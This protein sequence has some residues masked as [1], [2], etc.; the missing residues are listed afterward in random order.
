MIAPRVR[1]NVLR[2]AAASG[3]LALCLAAPQLAHAACGDGTLDVNEQC[4]DGNTASG[5]CCSATCSLEALGALCTDDGDVCTLDICSANGQ[6][7]HAPDPNCIVCGDGNVDT[8]EDCDDGN[9]DAGD[10]C[11]AT[12]KYEAEGSACTDDAQSC[13]LDQCNATGACQHTPFCGICGDGIVDLGEQCDD[14][15]TAAGDCCGPTCLNEGDGSLCDDGNPCTTLS[16]CGGGACQPALGDPDCGVDLDHFKC[17]QTK[18]TPGAPKFQR[19]TVTLADDFE[20]VNSVVTKPRSIC[21]PVSKNGGGI[22]DAT[23]HLTCY[24]TKDDRQAKFA[25]REVEVTNQFGV[26]QVR[27]LKPY[28]LCVPSEK[29]IVPAP[30]TP[31]ALNIDHFRCYKAKPKKGSLKVEGKIVALADQ[32]ET[33]RAVVG[34]SLR[35]C[36]PVDKNGEGIDDPSAHL[37]CYKLTRLRADLD[38]PFIPKPLNL[39]DQFGDLALT[40]RPLPHLCVPSL[41]P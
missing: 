19:Q 34:P 25:Q 30:P 16:A 40:A 21:N 38:P 36:N 28:Q 15:N 29:G 14:G 17:Y 20:S 26:Q 18:P 27:V 32:F 4:D 31:S 37:T 7:L 11:S 13:T 24:A 35:F 10:C 41:A 39:A 23:A 6:C 8:G 9:T 33:R 3:I 5:D 22:D 12:C 2:M 1:W